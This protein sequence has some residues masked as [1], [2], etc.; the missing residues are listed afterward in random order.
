MK[1]NILIVGISLV[2]FGCGGE[3][4][5]GSNNNNNNSWENS[6]SDFVYVAG[7]MKTSTDTDNDLYAP[8][9]DVAYGNNGD[10]CSINNDHYFE[11]A[12]VVVFGSAGY[13]DT[14]F[15]YAAT[16]VENNLDNALSAMGVTKVEFDNARPI[17]IGNTAHKI[18]DFMSSDFNI[19]LSDDTTIDD[20]TYLTLTTTF[21]TPADWGSMIYKE[22]YKHVRAYWNNLSASEQYVFSIEFK[23]V[24]QLEYPS[25]TFNPL[26]EGVLR[27][28][29][30]I[31]VCLTDMMD[32]SVYGEG[33]ILGMNLPPKSKV[34]RSNGDE[35]Q[36]VF[37][38]LIH[39]IQQNLASPVK[40]IGST[41]DHWFVEGQATYLAGQTTSSSPDSKNTPDVVL[42]TD[43]SSIFSAS[44]KVYSHYAL[45]YK[46]LED[47]KSSSS[48]MKDMLMD[49]RAFTGNGDIYSDQMVS[50][51]GFE[52]AFDNN[53]TRKGGN[54]LTLQEYK[55]SYQSIVNE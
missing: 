7:E 24:Y 3:S 52:F 50:S 5:S 22:R 18:I 44:D 30:K 11:S 20:I 43:E 16:L 6:G 15:K 51:A 19:V 35:S 29:K 12:N 14:D 4:D 27:I 10:A 54:D 13:P 17:F 39:T 38:E 33:T 2:L 48:Q 55:G 21:E 1:Q 45:A 25:N 41:M 26:G 9:S 46:Y 8:A 31:L 36:V 40:S 42:W 28:P 23:D 34:S 47:N 32:S 53:M 37:H 49:I